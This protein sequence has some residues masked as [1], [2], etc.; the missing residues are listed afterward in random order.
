[1]DLRR[2]LRECLSGR[3]CLMGLGNEDYGDDG[4]GVRLA[5]ELIEDPSPVPCWGVSAADPVWELQDTAELDGARPPTAAGPAWELQEAAQANVARR[6]TG[7]SASLLSACWGV[8]AAG[9]AWE[10]NREGAPSWKVMLAG[11]T[12]ERCISRAVS[13]GFQHLVFLDAVEFDGSPGD[14]VFLNSSE[15]QARFPQISTH[16]ISLGVLAMWA[17]ST[18]NTKAWLL[19]VQPESM[20]AGH[21]LSKTMRRTLGALKT[22]LLQCEPSRAATAANSPPRKRWVAAP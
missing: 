17:E 3:V 7:P 11:S 8:S 6:S 14:V 21:P 15:M 22:L 18:G 2:Q 5:E 1:M 20:K 4:F 10:L 19:G 9:P 12:P 16:K 13:E